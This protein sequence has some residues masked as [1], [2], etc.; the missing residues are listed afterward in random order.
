[1]SGSEQSAVEDKLELVTA[2]EPSSVEEALERA[3]LS[4]GDG[5]LDAAEALYRF[6]LKEDPQN[7][8]AQKALHNLQKSMKRAGKGG[9]RRKPNSR[10]KSKH[11]SNPALKKLSG[12]SLLQPQQSD[13]QTIMALYNSGQLVEAEAKA[14]KLIR[15]FPGAFKVYNLL[16]AV[17]AGLGKFD[18]AVACYKKSIELNPGFVDAYNNLGVI[19]RQYGKLEMAVACYRESLEINP[20][21]P[22]VHNN[23]GNALND[24]GRFEE[25]AASYGQAL[26]LQ[27]DYAEAHSNLGN[28]L[29]GLGQFEEAVASCEQALKIN[30]EYAH[31]Y[32]N[33]GGALGGL[34]RFEEAISSYEQAIRIKPD[35][36]DVFNNIGNMYERLNDLEQALKFT[37]KALEL[38]PD[39]PTINLSR[40]VLSKRAGDIQKAIE[41]L[42]PFTA[43]TVPHTLLGP[44]HNELGKLYDLSK[45]SETAFKYFSMANDLQAKCELSAAFNK[46]AFLGL[47]EQVDEILT[48]DWLDTWTPQEDNA[49]YETPA[50]L[51]GFPRSGTTLLDQI[52]DAHPA[53][54]VMEEQPPL[55]EVSIQIAQKSGGYPASVATL[56]G[57][58]I[59]ELRELYYRS[60]GSHLVR[61][62]GTLLVDKMPL[63]IHQIPLIARLFPQA[64][65]ILA[66]RHP[67]DVVLSNFMQHYKIN[68][69]M[70]NFFTLEDTAHCYAKVMG[71]WQKSVRLLPVNYHQ[72]KYE[73]LIDDFEGEVRSL[74]EFLA[75]GWD[76]AIRDYDQHARERGAI[77]TPSYQAVSEPINARARYR[78]KRYEDQ[79]APVMD[80]L[81]PFIEAFGYSEA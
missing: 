49:D 45:D 60:V 26:R 1:M 29:K 12:S 11:A 32:N 43:R 62:P 70:A 64:R 9:Q 61:E 22:E 73:S 3:S 80:D 46:Q 8:E 78:W 81:A 50:F 40:A 30:P 79:L 77:N 4:K 27:S 16:G 57:A 59:T 75:V 44:I 13:A 76:D 21:Y 69:A 2:A 14:V 72:F 10:Q 24:L 35:Y 66:L 67:C 41:L 31:A 6:V 74:L 39:D 65:I 55:H 54:Q 42:E 18:Q 68:A 20:D 58:D 28:A 17:R 15:K 56:D 63:H 48:A 19:Y 25:A 37:G 36:A 71:L 47:V 7:A 52:L 5:H 53:L 38:A 51:V 34:G 23:L 33:L